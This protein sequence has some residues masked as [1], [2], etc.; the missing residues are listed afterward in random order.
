MDLLKIELLREAVLICEAE[1]LWHTEMLYSIPAEMVTLPSADDQTKICLYVLTTVFVYIA[2][3][4]ALIFKSINKQNHEDT[5]TSSI[6][7][8]T[9]P[10]TSGPSSAPVLLWKKE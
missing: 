5:L 7:S 9:N 3:P 6:M 10:S 1:F 2:S 8:L 4:K